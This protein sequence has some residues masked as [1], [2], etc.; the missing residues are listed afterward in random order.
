MRLSDTLQYQI[1]PQSPFKYFQT[2]DQI[3]FILDQ[4]ENVVMNL[5]ITPK[6]AT[7]RLMVTT[8]AKSGSHFEFELRR[9]RKLKSVIINKSEIIKNTFE[10]KWS[11]DQYD[12]Q[13]GDHLE[14]HF[15]PVNKTEFAY[16]SSKADQRLSIF[17]LQNE[18][19]RIGLK[20]KTATYDFT[21]QTS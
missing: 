21:I 14:V 9:V 15:T 4:Y 10:V 7:H 6:T 19:I 3:K 16:F 5:T 11:S 18:L 17:V 20:L 12:L 1:Q 8:D 2:A 13:N